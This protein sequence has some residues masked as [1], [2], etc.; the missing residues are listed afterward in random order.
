ML[1][2]LLFTKG[3]TNSSPATRERNGVEGKKSI[4]LNLPRTFARYSQVEPNLNRTGL[5]LNVN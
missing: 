3:D 5:K 1:L 2:I 4:E